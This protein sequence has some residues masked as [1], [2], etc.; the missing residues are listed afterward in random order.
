MDVVVLAVLLLWRCG[1]HLNGLEWSVEKGNEALEVPSRD[2]VTYIRCEA[3]AELLSDRLSLPVFPLR[4]K[5]VPCWC[6]HP[7]Q[8]L[9]YL[10][11]LSAHFGKKWERATSKARVSGCDFALQYS[12]W[13]LLSIAAVFA[14]QNNWRRLGFDL[15]NASFIWW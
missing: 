15:H 5:K 4:L 9:R 1:E 6:S 13:I 10:S 14:F 12:S 7:S 3:R 2:L 8:L 11:R